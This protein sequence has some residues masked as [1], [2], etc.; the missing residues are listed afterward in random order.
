MSFAALQMLKDTG[1]DM[2]VIHADIVD[3]AKKKTAVQ[4]MRA[5]RAGG[6]KT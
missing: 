3:F 2:D 5:K 4:K 6:K 1:G